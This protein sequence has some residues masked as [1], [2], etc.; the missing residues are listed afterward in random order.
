MRPGAPRHVLRAVAWHAVALAILLW[1]LVGVEFVPMVDLPGHLAITRVLDDFLHGQFRTTLQ[2]NANPVHKPTYLLLYAVHATVPKAAVGPVAVGL[3]I[4]AFYAA[5]CSAIATLGRCAASSPLVVGLAT[6]VAMFSYGSMFFWGLMPFLLG[7]PPALVAYVAY[8]RASGIVDAGEQGGARGAATMRCVLAGSLAHLVHPLAS[9]FLGVALAGAAVAGIACALVPGL[10]GA[11]SVRSRVQSLAWPL[12]AWVAAVTVLQLLTAPAGQ[13][14]DVVRSLPAFAAPFHGVAAARTF[15]AQIPVELGMV[16]TRNPAATLV[17]FPVAVAGFFAA[18][19]DL[20]FVTAVVVGTRDRARR[21]AV[22]PAVRL[23]MVLVVSL[24]FF[25]FLRHDI[26]QP[27]RRLLW[28]AV[29]GPGFLVFF[30]GTL[31]AALVLRILPRGRGAQVVASV[32]AI[33]AFAVAGERSAVLHTHFVAFDDAVRGFFRGDVPDRYFRS[34]PFSYADHIRVYN[35][36]YDPT[37][38][39]LSTLFFAIYPDDAT[40]Y[41]VSRLRPPDAGASR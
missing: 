19:L 17:R 4:V 25:L 1:P 14:G 24:V 36:Y 33:A 12:A 41:P 27:T 9:L 8:L 37:C 21:I 7:I 15:L 40:I 13:G 39:D 22:A 26:V 11:R 3:M 5:V 28:Y 31:A 30:F 2:L 34:Q 6:L 35:C 16:P 23:G 18:A 29:R 38:G 10:A 32:L 20:A